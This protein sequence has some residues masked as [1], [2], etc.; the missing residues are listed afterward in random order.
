[1]LLCNDPVHA[2]QL[3]F[4]ACTSMQPWRWRP[5]STVC[6]RPV[7]VLWGT[8]NPSC[9]LCGHTHWLLWSPP[10]CA[11][12]GCPVAW[13]LLLTLCQ[14]HSVETVVRQ[15]WNSSL[16]LGFLFYFKLH[17]VKHPC[18]CLRCHNLDFV[19]RWCS[20]SSRLSTQQLGANC[21]DK[22]WL[23]IK[24][25]KFGNSFIPMNPKAAV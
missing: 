18:S 11:V 20:G 17:F 25:A 15:L 19:D 7:S 5:T 21:F 10:W 22:R 8:S 4:W 16:C 14:V 2:V 13:N 9:S 6:F 12:I 23:W 24:N 1:M 3:E